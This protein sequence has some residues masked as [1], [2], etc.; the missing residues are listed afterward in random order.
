MRPLR[1]VLDANVI[2]SALIRP[3]SAP[4][5]ILSAA[6]REAT[7]RLV[8]SDPLLEELRAAIEYPRL[9]RY[10]KMS[11]QEKDAFVI[12]LEQIADPISLHD[13]PAPG[14]C[15]DPDDEPYL[16]TALAGRADYIVSGDGDLLDLK[17]VE[18]IPIVTPADFE[19]ILKK[20][21]AD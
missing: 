11:R 3:D 18:H 16:R 2:I 9:Q 19:R 10:L 13:H 15:R 6:V 21:K 14:V 7:L 5:R 17:A 12:L 20:R 8:T 4:G 1:A